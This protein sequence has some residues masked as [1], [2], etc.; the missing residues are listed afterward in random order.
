MIFAEATLK[1]HIV[2]L[3]LSWKGLVAS[4][5]HGCSL[6]AVVS[7]SVFVLQVFTERSSC[8]SNMLTVILWVNSEVGVN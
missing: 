5:L 2:L 1:V 8:C 4:V 7:L 6:F 3:N